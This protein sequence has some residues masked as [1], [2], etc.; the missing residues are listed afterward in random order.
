MTLITK[1]ITRHDVSFRRASSRVVF[2]HQKT[3]P[4]PYIDF[5]ADLAVS[6]TFS[7]FFFSPPSGWNLEKEEPG[8]FKIANCTEQMKRGEIYQRFCTAILVSWQVLC[9]CVA[10]VA[11]RCGN[12]VHSD[13]ENYRYPSSCLI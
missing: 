10:S 5:F 3:L 13:S 11:N 12:A 4:F 6:P 2:S 8:E 1:V 7:F 9:N